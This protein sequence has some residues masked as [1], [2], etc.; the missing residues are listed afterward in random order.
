VNTNNIKTVGK[1]GEVV[2]KPLH[3]CISEG[4]MHVAAWYHGTPG[5]NFTKIR[6]ISF[7]RSPP[8]AANF[9]VLW[10]QEVYRGGMRC[11]L[12][13]ICVPR[14]VGQKFMLG[15]QICHQSIDCTSFYRH[16]VVTLALDCCISEISLVLY[17]KCTHT[18]RLSPKISTFPYS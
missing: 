7:D 18:P 15:H 4:L 17:C 11:P 14:K 9:V 5:P 6:G 8:N 3:K 16:S 1:H 12:S 10:R 13:K 2:E